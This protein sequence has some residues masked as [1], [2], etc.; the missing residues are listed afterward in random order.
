MHS[1]ILWTFSWHL[2]SWGEKPWRTMGQHKPAQ[3]RWVTWRE[4]LMTSFHS[5]SLLFFHSKPLQWELQLKAR[6]GS[7]RLLG[8]H[9]LKSHRKPTRGPGVSCASKNNHLIHCPIN[10]DLY[11]WR[12]IKS[13]PGQTG[14]DGPVFGTTRPYALMYG[15]FSK[16]TSLLLINN[17]R[18]QSSHASL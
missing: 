9:S 8:I 10:H 12:K 5:V 6:G 13:D 16:N 15:S 18:T 17:V 7:L 1:H 2:S 14:K 4:T 3:S 11:C